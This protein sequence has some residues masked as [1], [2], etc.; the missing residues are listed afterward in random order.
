MSSYYNIYISTVINREEWK[1]LPECERLAKEAEMRVLRQEKLKECRAKAQ[2]KPSRTKSDYSL[3]DGLVNIDLFPTGLATCSMVAYELDSLFGKAISDGLLYGKVSLPTYK[4]TMPLMIQGDYCKLYK[5]HGGKGR[6]G[7]YHEYDTDAEFY[8]AIMNDYKP[9][10]Y[11][12]FVN[13]IDFEVILGNPKKSIRLR[14]YMSDLFSG[15][16]E[17][18]QSTISFDTTGKKIFLNWPI[19]VTKKSNVE[20]DETKVIGVDLGLAVP[21]VCA[22]NFDIYKREKIGNYDDFL[23]K[24]VSIQNQRK[25]ILRDLQTASG[26]HGRKKKLHKLEQFKNYERNF[27]KSYNHMISK[28]VI[29]F[30]LKN[31]A[32]YINIEDLSNLSEKERNSFVLRNWSYYELQQFI[33]YKASFYGIIVRKVCPTYTSQT[34]SICGHRG[35]RNTQSLFICSNPDCKCKDIYVNG[36]NMN[37]D[38]NAARNIAMSTNFVDT[39]FVRHIEVK[40]SFIKDNKELLLKGTS[41]YFI[42]NKSGSVKVMCED[43]YFH[44]FDIMDLEPIVGK[45]NFSSI[46]DKLSK[47]T[48]T[49]KPKNVKKKAS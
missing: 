9:K 1:D 32:K 21:A 40:D 31:N 49:K 7:F 12:K 28:K 33:E 42:I 46:L 48:K 45:S 27:V 10:L 47:E 15:T 39:T 23:R 14:Q 18:C 30:A 6:G 17:G 34:C 4:S 35:I 37:A 20:L 22:T 13:G 29:D 36:N 25:R 26:G 43:N 24:R 41:Y 11:Y 19:Y 38:F 5:K 44:E 3:Y 8:Q 2:R 16:I